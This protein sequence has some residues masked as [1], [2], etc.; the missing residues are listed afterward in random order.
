MYFSFCDQKVNWLAQFW[1]KFTW[2]AQVMRFRIT[3]KPR[4]QRGGSPPRG[5][6]GR[7]QSCLCSG[8]SSGVFL[9]VRT[10]VALRSVWVWTCSC[11]FSSSPSSS[12]AWFRPGTVDGS[13]GPFPTGRRHFRFSPR[14][15]PASCD[16]TE[17]KV[18]ACWTL[19]W[20]FRSDESENTII[21][22]KV[23]GCLLSHSY[24]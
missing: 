4:D 21:V 2:R 14:R 9:R 22:Y 18:S 7:W 16:G 20:K 24:R 15:F 8:C 23:V 13:S 1:E 10:W 12:T 3:T 17:N 5:G 6:A 11:S 19:Q